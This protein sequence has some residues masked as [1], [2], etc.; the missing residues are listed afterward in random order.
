MNFLSCKPGTY[1]NT[2]QLRTSLAFFFTSLLKANDKSNS[3]RSSL[4]SAS[5]RNSSP[6]ILLPVGDFI[7]LTQHKIVIDIKLH[8]STQDRGLTFKFVDIVAIRLAVCTEK[9][10]GKLRGLDTR[11]KGHLLASSLNFLSR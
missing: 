7:R 5:S 3:S 8:D 4:S 6:F 11:R 1:S 2:V 9:R 10:T